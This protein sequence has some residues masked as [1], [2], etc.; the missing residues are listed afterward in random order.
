MFETRFSQR[1]AAA[2]GPSLSGVRQ[3]AASGH[4]RRLR[5]INLVSAAMLAT[6]VSALTVLVERLTGGASPWTFAVGLLA[7]WL[8]LFLGLGLLARVSFRL[9]MRLV[10]GWR[11]RP[12]TDAP[13]ASDHDLFAR[14]RQDRQLS[15]D[16][17]PLLDADAARDE[18]HG[19]PF[20]AP[21]YCRY[22]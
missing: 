16:V 11:V 22:L 7:L 21:R 10:G 3:T 1:P 8:V 18:K 15:D 14:M 2:A 12:R 6:V 4:Q 9:A 17:Q 13:P 20:V 19:T 5:S